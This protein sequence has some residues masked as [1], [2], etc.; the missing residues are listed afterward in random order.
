M[1]SFVKSC[2]T[3]Q[4]TGLKDEGNKYALILLIPAMRVFLR[5]VI[6]DPF[7][8]MVYPFLEDE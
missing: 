7:L 4:F 2:K 8:E 1:F 3:L 5:M 6:Y